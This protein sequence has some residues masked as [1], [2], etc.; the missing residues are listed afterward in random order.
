MFSRGGVLGIV[1]LLRRQL[2]GLFGRGAAKI[3][4]A[5]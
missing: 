4:E 3:G 5:L 1:D 2:A